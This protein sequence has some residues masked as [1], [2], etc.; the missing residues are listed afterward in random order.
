M[1]SPLNSHVHLN[2]ID[3]RGTRRQTYN[4][5]RSK[6]IGCESGVFLI[7][8]H[9]H[10]DR[11]VKQST[12]SRN[13]G[14]KRER[15][16]ARE[17]GVYKQTPRNKFVFSRCQVPWPGLWLSVRSILFSLAGDWAA[18]INFTECY[19]LLI[20]LANGACN[21]AAAKPTAL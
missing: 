17:R 3:H 10:R 16:R 7:N 5:L 2:S 21:L 12:V 9:G 6:G 15:G 4:E 8:N 18:S 19:D 14:A 20:T 11:E 13:S 1:S